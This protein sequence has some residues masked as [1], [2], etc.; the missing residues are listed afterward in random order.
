[1][2]VRSGDRVAAGLGVCSGGGG[3]VE[4]AMG[5]GAGVSSGLTSDV[6]WTVGVTRDLGVDPTLAS[7][8]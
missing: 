2:G 6:T 4:E 1:M 3:G 5:E 8:G 7:V